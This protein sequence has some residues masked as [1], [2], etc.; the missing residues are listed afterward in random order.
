MED[1][2]RKIETIEKEIQNYYENSFEEGNDDYKTNKLIKEKIKHLII[3]INNLNSDVIN[4]A[5]LVLAKSTGCTE[6]QE[7]AD[8]IINNLHDNGYI[9]EK[10]LNYF[11]D[12]TAI[13]RWE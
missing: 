4:R 10:Q 9:D 11:Y 1:Y 6:D 2:F 5:L 7:I 13:R 12:N 3:K 8:N